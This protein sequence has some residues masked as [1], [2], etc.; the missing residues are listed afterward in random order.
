ML[1]E[2]DEKNLKNE[3]KLT[4][5][6]KSALYGSLSPEKILPT[7]EKALPCPICLNNSI[8]IPEFKKNNYFEVMQ[9][10]QVDSNLDIF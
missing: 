6:P 4:R 8:E 2:M 3:F 5:G 1:F 7:I 9:N 10:I